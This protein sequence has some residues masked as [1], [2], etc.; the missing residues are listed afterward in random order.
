MDITEPTRVC[1]CVI[2]NV[3]VVL[4]TEVIGPWGSIIDK[5]NVPDEIRERSLAI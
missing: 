3:V 2:F 4:P 1:P 5:L